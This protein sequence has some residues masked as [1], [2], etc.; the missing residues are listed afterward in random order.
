MKRTTSRTIALGSLVALVGTALGGLL[1]PGTAHAAD[2]P[3]VT[4]I[5]SQ[6][7]DFTSSNGT[8]SDL[9]VA[10]DGRFV[11]FTSTATNLV[12][13]TSTAVARVYLHDLWTDEVTLVSRT[14]AGAPTSTTARA[15]G[16]SKGGDYVVFATADQLTA[17][18]TNAVADVYVWER[19][20]AKVELVSKAWG[21]AQPNGESGELAGSAKA[22]VSDTGRYVA[23]T[24]KATNLTAAADTNG[25]ADIFRRDRQSGSTSRVNDNGAQQLNGDSF[26]PDMSGDGRY[27]TWGTVATNL[28][29]T[30]TNG[31]GDIAYRDLNQATPIKISVGLDANANGSSLDPRISGTGGVVVFDSSASD[32]VSSDTNGVRD[33]FA[34]NVAGGT[35]T[36]ISV[37][38]GTGAQLPTESDD[39]DVTYGGVDFAFA[40]SA[41]ASAADTDAT[42]DVYERTGSSSILQSISTTGAADSQHVFDSS[43]SDQ[44]M[45]FTTTGR[46]ATTDTNNLTDAFV[47]TQPFLGPFDD[48]AGFAATQLHRVRG[49][50]P[51]LDD[52]YPALKRLE[53]GASPM[54]FVTDLVDEPAFS[55]KRAPV[56]R[57]YWAYFKRRPDL[58]GLNHWLNKYRN[59]MRLVD[60][61]QQFA[62]SSEFKNTYG[63]TTPEQFVT[64]VYQN[65]LE[66]QPESTGLAYWAKKIATGTP[67]GQVMT[68][69]SESS[70]G[71]RVI[72]PRSDTIL[73]ALGM[74]GKIPSAPL[75]DAAVDAVQQG[76]PRE[77]IVGYVLGAP[78]YAATM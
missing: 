36:R 42:W 57:L 38:D 20:T 75:F 17:E 48:L 55:A 49:V 29:G 54:R 3:M 73:I 4:A 66:R 67:R 35:T 46:L 8:T 47:R 26:T 1:G 11:V 45:G 41:K 37:A 44:G 58:G 50:E 21:G 43:I 2:P 19:A 6:S 30:D 23:F 28:P 22:S 65:V 31:S 33:V 53:A 14:A 5:V 68:N 10:K 13:D 51:T 77:L 59:G 60:I 78:E 69:F 18:D 62:R 71:R 24:S 7:E 61:S 56:V 12:P 52:V 27:L 72:G 74:Y 40:T 39:G 76:E 34:R 70:E 9:Y 15:S 16:V 64:L 32:L 63:N 25:K